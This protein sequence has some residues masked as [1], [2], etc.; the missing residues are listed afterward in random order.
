MTSVTLRKV[1]LPEFDTPTLSLSAM[2]KLDKLAANWLSTRNPP[3]RWLPS[4]VTPAA[5]P[6][7]VVDSDVLLNSSTPALSM[8][9][10]VVAKTAGSNVMA[11]G[12]ALALTRRSIN[13]APFTQPP[14]LASI[15]RVDTKYP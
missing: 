5:G 10:C 3:A 11:V 2:V 13:R 8:M 15:F 14:D 1:R 6:V 7:I 9:V 12:V 4:S